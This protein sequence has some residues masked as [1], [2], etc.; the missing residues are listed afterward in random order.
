VR[1]AETQGELESYFAEATEW[2]R[3]RAAGLQ[4]EVRV[5]WRIC[6]ASVVCMVATSVALMC[7]MPLKQVS[8]FL[9]RVD[10]SSG[11]VDVVPVFTGQAPMDE[12]V[13]RYFLTHYI[14]TCERFNLTTA[15]SDY[16]ECGA[17]HSA[18]RNQAWYAR[19]NRSN[20]QSPLNVHKDGSVVEVQVSAV[21]FFQRVNAVA[22]TAQV[23]YLKIERA[24]LG[25]AERTSHWIA[26]LRYSYGAPPSDPKVRRWNPIGFRVQDFVSEAEVSGDVAASAV[27]P[28]SGSPR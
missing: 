24:G 6:I 12:T 20:P 27:P 7:A 10:S 17:F 22:D 25:A 14:S 15:E 5:A 8:Q 19:W 28:Q 2:D 1:A 13:T 4:R 21:S 23:R 16:E 3:D 9:I 18:Q 26:T 11:V